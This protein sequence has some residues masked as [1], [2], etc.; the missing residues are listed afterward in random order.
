MFIWEKSFPANEQM[1]HVLE[2]RASQTGWGLMSSGRQG[3]SE[4]VKATKCR[5]T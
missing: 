3:W 1:G 4:G 2:G 5:H